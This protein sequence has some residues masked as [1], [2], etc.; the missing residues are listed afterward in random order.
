MLIVNMYR[1]VSKVEFRHYMNILNNKLKNKSIENEFRNIRNRI[2]LRK[3]YRLF[4]FYKEELTF[5]R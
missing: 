2:D 3:S 5:T 4:F 1:F